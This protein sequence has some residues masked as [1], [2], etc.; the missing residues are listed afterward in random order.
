M[1]KPKFWKLSHGYKEFSYSELI[2]SIVDRKA[3]IH[4]NT[5]GRG[6]ETKSQAQDFIDADIGDYFYL[7]HGNTGIYLLGQ[8][9]GP[10]NIFTKFQDGWLSRNY[11]VVLM[12]NKK[13]KFV[14]ATKKCWTPNDNS[15]FQDVPS[16]EMRDFEELILKPHFDVEL[17]NYGIDLAI[18]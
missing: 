9:T 2:E 6:S 10:A 18:Y 8:F 4:N 16:Y 12:A 11:D 15:T 13:D 5:K 14:G 1:L 17:K 3:Y 7:T